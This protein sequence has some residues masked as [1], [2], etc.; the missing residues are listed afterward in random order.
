MGRHFLDSGNESEQERQGLSSSISPCLVRGGRCLINEE[1]D[2]ATEVRT[3]GNMLGT[4]GDSLDRRGQVGDR[5]GTTLSRVVKEDPSRE[6][7]LVMKK[8]GS[9]MKD[10]LSQGL[11]MRSRRPVWHKSSLQ[12]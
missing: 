3:G 6:V 11:D 12:E 10:K 7:T 2:K 5:W 1:V 8:K 9:S 4:G